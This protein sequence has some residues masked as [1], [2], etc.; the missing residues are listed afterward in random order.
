[1]TAADITLPLELRVASIERRGRGAI[2]IITLAT[3]DGS[4]TPAWEP[5]AHAEL[6]LPT[7]LTRHFSLCGPTGEGRD[8][9]LGVLR[10]TE[11]RGG[12]EYIHST[13]QP[14]DIVEVTA[15]R[16][17]FTLVDAPSY[18]FIAAGIGVTPFL[19]M[20]ETLEQRG[21]DWRAIYIARS[22]D[23]LVF[24]DELEIYGDRVEFWPTDE[25]GRMDVAG[26]VG[27]APAGEAVYA[28]GPVA[29]L[30][31]I[32]EGFP[33]D[34]MADLH[35]ERFRPRDPEPDRHDAP[36]EVYLDYSE[37]LLHVPAD[38]SIADVVEEAGVEIE[39][40]CREGTCGTCETVVLE[41]VP[42]HR[43]VF[44]S[45][46]ERE[47]NEVMMICCSRSKSPRLVLDL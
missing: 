11:G 24:A 17:N 7:G 37:L 6:R 47:S 18:L 22:R 12:S 8:W 30:D 27:A 23:A 45:H 1:M 26:L 5:G 3:V 13:L 25:R 31:A 39:T 42:E 34:R 28:C 46:A 10:E 38:R 35:L 20:F 43:D 41:G 19:P 9:R 15:V 44:L 21:E 2:A 33:A 32:E 29:L 16:N 14:G 4:P 40:S 36:F